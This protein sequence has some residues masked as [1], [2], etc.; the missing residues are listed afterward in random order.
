[1]T[2][3]EAERHEGF[4]NREHDAR[5]EQLTEALNALKAK[6]DLYAEVL[7]VIEDLRKERKALRNCISD[8]QDL[9]YEALY[10]CREV[11]TTLLLRYLG[12]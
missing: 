5:A 11:D 9:L 7:L 8:A 12:L 1:M 2:L 10:E 4:W 3:N 6:S